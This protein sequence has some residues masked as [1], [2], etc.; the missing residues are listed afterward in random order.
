MRTN[1]EV[2]EICI[3]ELE[4]LIQNIKDDKISDNYVYAID[5]LEMTNSFEMRAG[6]VRYSVTRNEYRR[7]TESKH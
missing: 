1:E 7:R 5:V 6:V 4:E 3:K 2:K